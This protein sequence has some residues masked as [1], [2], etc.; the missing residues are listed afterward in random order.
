MNICITKEK[1]HAC[2]P[3]LCFIL[4]GNIKFKDDFEIYFESWRINL[5]EKNKQ[6]TFQQQL[7]ESFEYFWP[8][9]SILLAFFPVLLHES[10]NIENDE[11]TEKEDD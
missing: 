11:E 8:K 1:V 9:T 10:Q 3:I 6:G 4:H 5:E 2:L 7:L